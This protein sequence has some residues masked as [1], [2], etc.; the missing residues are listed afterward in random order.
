MKDNSKVYEAKRIASLMEGID[1]PTIQEIVDDFLASKKTALKREE[2]AEYVAL[3]IN[4]TLDQSIM[5][6]IDNALSNLRNQDK[7][8]NVTHGYWQTV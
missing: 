8:E 6:V 3:K 1:L 5:G 4:L 2:I 7:I